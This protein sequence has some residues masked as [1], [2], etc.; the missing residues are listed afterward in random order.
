MHGIGKWLYT[1]MPNFIEVRRSHSQA[2]LKSGAR[3]GYV[4]ATGPHASAFYNAG[5]CICR[6]CLLKIWYLALV[7]REHLPA[8]KIIP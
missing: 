4:I 5:G 3:T 7:S 6:D 1:V 2:Q 8:F